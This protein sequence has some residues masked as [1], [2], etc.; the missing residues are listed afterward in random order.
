[1][2]GLYGVFPDRGS[3]EEAIVDAGRERSATAT[4]APC[5]TRPPS[6][7]ANPRVARAAVCARAGVT[8][9]VHAYAASGAL[10]TPAQFEKAAALLLEGYLR[11]GPAASDDAP[12]FCCFAIA[13]EDNGRLVLGVDRLGVEQLFYGRRGK[14]LA[15]ATS[16]LVL[17]R[18]LGNPPL[19]R[20]GLFDYLYSHVV[21]SPTTIFDGIVRLAPGERIVWHDGNIARSRYWLP[22]YEESVR[23]PFS[24]LR[25]EFIAVLRAATED[26]I[27][28]ARPGAF[29]SGGTDSSTIAGM[30]GQCS[31]RAASTYS[32]GFEAE[33]YDEMAFA[34]IT[35]KHFGTDHHEYYVTPDDVVAAVPEL[36]RI[37][38]QPLGNASAVPA[39]YCAR[40]AAADGVQRMIAGDGGDELF[41]GNARYATQYVF[42]LYE[43]IPRP[44]RARMVEPLARAIPASLPG[45]RKLRSYVEQACV[46]MPERT[47]TYNLLQRFGVTEVFPQD[48]LAGVDVTQPMRARAA[49][50]FNPTAQSLINRQLAMDL[51]FTLA[52]N[53][54]PKVVRSCE[55]AGLPVAFPMLDPRVVD[56]S[57]RLPPDLKL[58]GP[59]LRYFFKQAL[60]GFLPEATVRKSKHGFGLPFGPWAVRHA[61]LRELAFDSIADLGDRGIFNRSW[62]ATLPPRLVEHPAYYGTMV[63]VLMMLEQWL[64]Q[65]A[66]AARFR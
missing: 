11:R 65:H 24:A 52:D 13:D 7:T 15:F 9:G 25:D 21:T 61:R 23:A 62:L 33:G 59:R 48:F 14:G 6:I 29:L 2:I 42:S 31:G 54:L 19:S 50:Y 51:K 8:V 44:L 58:R 66:P 37:H 57:L 56:F 18:L 63:W 20:E 64:K 3:E 12:A 35:A 38:D 60:R 32:I 43:S 26:A 46:A 53:D 22:R 36:A 1:M 27:V 28:G 17:A 4:A 16:A 34:R 55:L 47:E 10:G 5:A 39:Y 49:E 40:L 41:G 30:I 45:L